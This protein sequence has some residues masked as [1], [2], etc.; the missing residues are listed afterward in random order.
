MKSGLIFSHADSDQSGPSVS[1]VRLLDYGSQAALQPFVIRLSGHASLRQLHLDPVCSGQQS[2]K[3]VPAGFPGDLGAQSVSVGIRQGDRGVSQILIPVPAVDPRPALQGGIADH[4]QHKAVHGTAFFY[5]NAGHFHTALRRAEC[6]VAFRR[7]I[8]IVRHFIRQRKGSGDHAVRGKNA[9]RVRRQDICH[10]S[11]AFIDDGDPAAL[12]GLLILIAEAV[13]VFV[14]PEFAA[15]ASGH[16][17]ADHLIH[18]RAAHR[19]VECD[20]LLRPARGKRQGQQAGS[21]RHPVFRQS[22]CQRV[23]VGVQVCQREGT[24]RFGNDRYG[25]QI[26]PCGLQGDLHSRKGALVPVHRA[27]PVSVTERG[28]CD[29]AQRQCAA[30]RGGPV[31]ARSEA[32]FLALSGAVLTSDR[33]SAGRGFRENGVFRQLIPQPVSSGHHGVKKEASA[34]RDHCAEGFALLAHQPDHSARKA[35]LS[36]VTYTVVVFVC[37]NETLHRTGPDHSRVHS[38]NRLSQRDAE[39][40]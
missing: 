29:P 33:I 37:E 22:E 10:G 31:V 34:F 24:V 39:G 4:A 19:Y 5:G 26:G 12:R 6:A 8:R 2:C 3:R 14:Q 38:F 27:R 9:L 11:V 23:A 40:F 17:A 1:P 15:Q 25:F 21:C 18:P 28:A 7:G 20:R 35:V 36:R 16:R 30:Q 13:V 32:E